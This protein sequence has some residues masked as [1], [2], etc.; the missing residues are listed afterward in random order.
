VTT[1]LITLSTTR[2]KLFELKK[3]EKK[4]NPTFE[5]KQSESFNVYSETGNLSTLWDPTMAML[6]N[7]CT[8]KKENERHTNEWRRG[9]ERSNAVLYLHEI[10]TYNKPTTNEG[11][12]QGGR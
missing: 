6:A 5:I 12:P 9:W 2:R 3:G 10:E 7:E 11:W 4:K 8:R 1:S